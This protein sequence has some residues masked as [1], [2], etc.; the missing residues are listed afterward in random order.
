[1]T[2]PVVTDA[3]VMRFLNAFDRTDQTAF[4]GALRKANVRRGLE[5]ALTEPE[6][7]P[8]SDE[9]REAGM[10]AYGGTRAGE[11][12]AERVYRAMAPLDPARG[13]AEGP[14]CIP[15][16]RNHFRRSDPPH[17]RDFGHMREDDPR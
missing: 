10:T 5:A 15:G 3:M 6:E 2:K 16:V 17:L 4:D 11:N 7:I 12:I 9:M 14:K 1:M 8:V 13:R